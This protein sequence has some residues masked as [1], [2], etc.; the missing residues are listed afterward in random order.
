[1]KNKSINRKYYNF[2]LK[3]SKNK[4]GGA[5]NN[6]NNNNNNSDNDSS[7]DSSSSI[8]IPSKKIHF[9]IPIKTTEIK[10]S[11][12]KE[13][14]IEN[15]KLTSV[16]IPN[17]VN[18]IKADA[19]YGSYFLLEINIPNSVSVIEDN[20]FYKCTSL[21]KV[22]I[23][24]SVKEIGNYAFADCKSLVDVN[25]PND[26]TVLEENV[27]SNC[28]KLVKITI[29]NKVEEIKSHTFFSCYSL[30]EIIIPESV[31]KIGP[32]AFSYCKLLKKIIILGESLKDVDVTSFYQCPALEIVDYGLIS[33]I[34][35]P[36]I[37]PLLNKIRRT[38]TIEQKLDTGDSCVVR[39]YWPA[40]KKEISINNNLDPVTYE[41]TEPEQLNEI[42]DTKGI[43]SPISLQDLEGNEYEIVDFWKENNTDFKKLAAK[44]HPTVLGNTNEWHFLPSELDTPIDNIN[45]NDLAIMLARGEISLSES[46]LLAWKGDVITGA[47]KKKRNKGKS[48][49]GKVSRKK[50]RKG[51]STVGK[52]SRKKKR[53]GKSTIG[54]VSR[55]KKRKGKSTIGK[56][57]RK[58]KRNKGKKGKKGKKRQKTL[59]GR[60]TLRKKHSTSFRSRSSLRS[61]TKKS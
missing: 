52:V 51:K 24:N 49:V 28:S 7:N 10:E 48:T 55:K 15:E 9:N 60:R 29:P 59:I 32:F 18:K 30:E 37:F 22:V 12:W 3:K 19:F 47:R 38:A 61:R 45:S 39:R 5:S 46:W 13:W 25:I 42:V 27:F 1:M 26:I 33:D 41:G 11:S 34:N 40:S 43:V 20:S 17:T 36:N 4:K 56:V 8:A 16:T 53:K 58:K 35:R 57:S 21:S 14:G 54:K 44:Q 2:S 31:K 6:N 23:P 50:K